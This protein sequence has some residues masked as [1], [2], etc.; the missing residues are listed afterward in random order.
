MLTIKYDYMHLSSCI[1]IF[2]KY[3][4]IWEP[5]CKGIYCSMEINNTNDPYAISVMKGREVISHMPYKISRMCAIFMRNG[6]RI[7]CAVI[8]IHHCSCDLPQGIYLNNVIPVVSIVA[9]KML[10]FQYLRTRHFTLITMY[11]N[12]HG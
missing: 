8:K 11:I 9:Q 12:Y 10:I 7:K 3:Q 4:A 2:H 5:T 6:L 1:H